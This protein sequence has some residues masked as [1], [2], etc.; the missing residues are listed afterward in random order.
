VREAFDASLSLAAEESICNEC[1]TNR[2][3]VDELKAVLEV[4]AAELAGA[5]K[6]GPPSE[7]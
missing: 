3:K 5:M 6:G 4:E 1:V 7:T 2:E